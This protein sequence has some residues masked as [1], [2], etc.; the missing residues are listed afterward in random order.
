MPNAKAGKTALR[1]EGSFESDTGGMMPLVL[2]DLDLE[3]A[4]VSRCAQIASTH[5]CTFHSRQQQP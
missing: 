2:D 3:T 5:Q 4:C 1:F